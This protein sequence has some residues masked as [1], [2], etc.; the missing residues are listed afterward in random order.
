MDGVRP[1]NHIHLHQWGG[2][3]W[4]IA[5]KKGHYS[6]TCKG[7]KW[8]NVIYSMASTEKLHIYTFIQSSRCPLLVSGII[9][10]YRLFCVSQKLKS[11]LILNASLIIFR[12]SLS[13]LVQDHSQ[14]LS[15]T[16]SIYCQRNIMFACFYSCQPLT[17]PWA[18]ELS[19]HLKEA[20][21]FDGTGYPVFFRDRSA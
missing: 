6:C 17:H 2:N 14:S 1:H 18:S 10:T 9:T 15:A 13:K 3:I 8:P 19:S 16:S 21:H 12:H 20:F 7:K 5:N 4:K 11:T